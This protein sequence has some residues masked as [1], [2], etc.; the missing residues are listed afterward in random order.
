MYANQ[1][2]DTPLFFI[3]VLAVV[4]YGQRA[5]K[6]RTGTYI[7][8]KNPRF[9]WPWNVLNHKMF[10]FFLSTTTA[11]ITS[12]GWREKCSLLPPSLYFF[13]MDIFVFL[14]WRP[15]EREGIRRQSGRCCASRRKR[16]SW[17]GTTWSWNPLRKRCK[18]QRR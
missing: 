1:R 12:A 17:A 4:L 2:G 18:L 14:L 11:E 5:G 7:K 3:D 10:P 16:S 15:M 6:A 13:S 9:C 8:I